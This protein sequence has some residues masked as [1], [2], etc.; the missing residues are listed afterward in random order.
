MGYRRPA[1]TILPLTESPCPLIPAAVVQKTAAG[2]LGSCDRR[3]SKGRRDYA[4]LVIVLRLG[5]RPGEV[6]HLRLDDLDWRAGEIVVH[7][8]AV[9]KTGSRC[10][11]TWVRRWPPICAGDARPAPCNVSVLGD[12][13]AGRAAYQPVLSGV[14]IIGPHRLR[15]TL[16]CQMAN[17]IGYRTTRLTVRQ[18]QTTTISWS[19]PLTFVRLNSEEQTTC[20]EVVTRYGRL[21]ESAPCLRQVPISLP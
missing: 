2:L 15:H 11:A 12:S 7:A 1:I 16:A 18:S 3:S 8:K 14:P 17:A 10:Q 5:L 13:R 4:V 21:R 19:W 6:A 9:T 20:V